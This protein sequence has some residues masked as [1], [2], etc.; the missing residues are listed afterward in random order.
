MTQETGTDERSAALTSP[1]ARDQ[2]AV[3]GHVTTLPERQLAVTHWLLSS[4][5]DRDRVRA[6]WQEPGGIALLPCGGLFS[7]VRV[8]AHLVW[9]TAGTQEL[10]KVDT[11]LRR[12]FD[13]G[14]ATMDLH[15]LLYY[16]LVPASTAWRWSERQFPGVAC[17]GRDTYLGMPA[18]QLTEPK[19]SGYWC[20][21]MESSGDLCYTD[22]LEDLIRIGRAARSEEDIW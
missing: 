11:F 12:W 1:D 9:A 13:G 21:P 22:E 14:A 10:E 18:V 20:V 2:G 17:L 15:G 3:E 5:K 19:G 4:V 8:P 16:F 7:A 6:Q